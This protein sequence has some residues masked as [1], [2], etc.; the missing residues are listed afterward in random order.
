MNRS[1]FIFVIASLCAAAPQAQTVR[2]T[3]VVTK[4]DPSA[5][6]LVLKTD[7]GAEV[8]VTLQPKANY[9]RIAPGEKDLRSAQVIAAGDIHVGDRAQAV[10]KAGEDG[11]SIAAMLIVVMSKADVAKKQ[12]AEQAEWDKRGVVGIVTAANPEDI[13]ISVNSPD[14]Q[15]KTLVITPAPNALIRR[16][17]PDSIKFE[18]AKPSTLAE[19]RTGDQVRALGDKSPDGTKMTAEEI[20]SGSFKEIAATIISIDPSANEMK[21][22]DLATKKPVTVK[23]NPESNLRKLPAQMA[24]MLA[25]RNRPPE[26]DGRG[27]RP[28]GPP[29]GG[30]FGRGE[31]RGFG[32][33]GGRGGGD[34]TKMLDTVPKMTLADL[35]KGDAVIVLS[36]VG[37]TPDQMT[38]ITMLAGVEP[39][40]TRPG[41]R[42]MQLGEWSLGGLGGGGEP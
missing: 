27:G 8:M 26:A 37:T 39:I 25:A 38:A 7:A 18:D 22:T 13:A 17:A 15:K 12:A 19:I 29:E 36:T 4:I 34:L 30:G 41:T 6:Q 1:I 3:G 21:V 35:K 32:G 42:D 20:V 9:R 28:G 2:Q 24:Q 11:K 14:G 40:L 16:Y 31:G 10:G 33:R 5:N 23:I